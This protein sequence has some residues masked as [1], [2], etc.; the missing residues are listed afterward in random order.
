MWLGW[1]GSGPREFWTT[2]GLFPGD[3]LCG[4]SRLSPNSQVRS[5]S[6]QNSKMTSSAPKAGK[7]W[8]RRGLVARSEGRGAIA[9]GGRS[10]GMS[11]DSPGRIGDSTGMSGDSV[12]KEG[13]FTGISSYFRGMSIWFRGMGSDSGGVGSRCC[14]I[15]RRFSGLCIKP[16]GKARMSEI[17][18]DTCRRLS[19]RNGK[20]FC[21][22]NTR[23]EA[24]ARTPVSR[25]FAC[26]AG[27]FLC[28][29]AQQ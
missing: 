17:S 29:A 3:G 16:A 26:F 2:W 11:G 8:W 5:P 18:P 14:G 22:R 10:G 28:D 1:V 23:K 27:N 24:K 15:G 20:N 7:Y 9:M 21:P 6:S 13:R 25:P 19:L 4:I 12:G